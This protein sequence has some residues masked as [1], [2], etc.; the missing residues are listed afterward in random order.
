MVYVRDKQA[1]EKGRMHG[2]AP[3]KFL[4]EAK[5]RY[6]FDSLLHDSSRALLQSLLHEG[7]FR[8]L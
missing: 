8:S 2:E 3:E 6:F 1:A 5:A 4:A 7:F